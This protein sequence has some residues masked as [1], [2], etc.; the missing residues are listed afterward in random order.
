MKYVHTFH[1][2]IHGHTLYICLLVYFDPLPSSFVDLKVKEFADA[3][4]DGTNISV[5]YYSELEVFHV[6]CCS[7]IR[8]L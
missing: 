1:A 4:G 2:I 7:L 5:F 8:P 6:Y 3:I